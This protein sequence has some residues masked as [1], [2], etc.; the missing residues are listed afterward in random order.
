MK[1]FFETR[2]VRIVQRG[3]LQNTRISSVFCHFY[4]NVVP[5]ASFLENLSL[6]RGFHTNLA[7]SWSPALWQLWSPESAMLALKAVVLISASLSTAPTTCQAL[8]GPSTLLTMCV[9]SY[10]S[11]LSVCL[12]LERKSPNLHSWSLSQHWH[13]AVLFHRHLLSSAF[14][15]GFQGSKKQCLAFLFTHAP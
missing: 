13:N 9:S 3:S 7:S 14:L 15:L 6:G 5:V 2:V 8:G 1:A 12:S 4:C 10:L 11:Y